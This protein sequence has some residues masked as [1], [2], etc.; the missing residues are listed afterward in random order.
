LLGAEREALLG[1]EREVLMLLLEHLDTHMKQHYSVARDD[2]GSPGGSPHA[3]WV[4]NY[5]KIEIL[6]RLIML[7]AP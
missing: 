1:A 7:I 4:T 6:P 5:P 2:A 3:R